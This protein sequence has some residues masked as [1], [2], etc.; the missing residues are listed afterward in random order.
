MV[1]TGPTRRQVAAGAAL[2]VVGFARGAHAQAPASVDV[3]LELVLAV[4][5]SGSVSPQ[6]FELQKQG[7]VAAFRD[8]RV[9]RAIRSGP[10]RS[11][12]V[13]L[14]QWTGPRLQ[15]TVA[16][17]TRIHDE[18]SA[19]AFAD[20]VEDAGRLLFGGGTSI[21]GAIDHGVAQFP[22]SGFRSARRVIDVSGDGANTSG[23]DVTQ[24]RDEAVAAGLVVNGLPILSIEFDLD[25][26]YKQNVI[27]GFGAFMIPAKDFGVFA[28]A[29]RRK[30]IAEIAAR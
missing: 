5:A 7:Y 11:I 26:Y 16:A 30:L 21:S 29:I 24:A 14:Y 13:T 28:D 6:R 19:N 3:D 22:L 9:L 20:T 12:A 18:A 27:G 2:G 15:R 10:T 23:R 1:A 8:P 4:D 25:V 17:W